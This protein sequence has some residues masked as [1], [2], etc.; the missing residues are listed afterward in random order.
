MM[1][2]SGKA[3]R[4]H[5]FIVNQSNKAMTDWAPL[6]SELKK[7]MPKRIFK[8]IEVDKIERWENNGKKSEGLSE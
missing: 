4:I 5:R 8:Q 2:Q 1:Y 7:L 6:P 3:Y